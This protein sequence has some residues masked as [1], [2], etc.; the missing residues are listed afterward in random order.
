MDQ[1]WIFTLN[2]EKLDQQVRVVCIGP[3]LKIVAW[4][5]FAHLFWAIVETIPVQYYQQNKFIVIHV[6][7]SWRK[8]ED[9]GEMKKV[10]SL[11]S[12]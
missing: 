9:F 8:K 1:K 4:I 7:K 10:D 2:L 11:V 12:I 6:F 3:D 5:A